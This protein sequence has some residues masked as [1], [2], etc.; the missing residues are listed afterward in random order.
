M[1][2]DEQWETFT[3]LVDEAWPGDFDDAARSSWRVLLDGIEPQAALGALKRLLYGGHHWRPSVSELLAEA[4]RD[5]SLPTFEEAWRVMRLAL[6]ARASGVGGQTIQAQQD[7]RN[8]AALQRANAH[9]PAIRA[10]LERYG[11][12]RLRMLPVDDP[13]WGEKHLKDLR[14]SW[15]RHLS[16]SDTRMVAALASGDRDGLRRLDPAAALALG[17]GVDQRQGGGK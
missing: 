16:A 14:D 4:K 11:V 5:P 10:F 17:A 6:K 3:A 7:A 1:W 12:D 15:E 8:A 2:E 9:H 13:E